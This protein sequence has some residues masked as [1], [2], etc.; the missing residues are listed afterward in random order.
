[1]K[2]LV[3]GGSGFLGTRLRKRFQQLGYEVENFDLLD[4]GR[5]VRGAVDVAMA[6]TGK[7]V[8][9]HLAAISNPRDVFG[10]PRAARETNVHGT[11]NVADACLKAG[12]RMVFASSCSIYG[13]QRDEFYPST[14]DV[15]IQPFEL[16]TASKAAGEFLIRT[17]NFFHSEK[18]SG[19]QYD[20]MRFSSLYGPNMR[21][22]LVGWIFFNKAVK[23]EPLLIFGDGLQTRGWTYVDD[24]VDGL[25]KLLN[26]APLN[27][28]INL[29][30]DEER[31]VL[32]VAK[33]IIKV[34]NSASKIEFPKPNEQQY[35][36][37]EAPTSQRAFELLGWRAET[38]LEEGLEK[39]AEW[40][41]ENPS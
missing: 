17:N 39:T 14:E 10:D 7:D 6:V 38:S 29:A 5:D 23:N 28:V 3:T 36:I 13:N 2:V 37:R 26:V 22:S 40:F 33:Q 11:L 41:K 24:V 32:D 34:T 8:V 12:T 30:N 19:L 18:C 31:T 20:I 1:M 27:Q 9:Y 21:K 25:V 15:A 4:G 16:Y 35:P